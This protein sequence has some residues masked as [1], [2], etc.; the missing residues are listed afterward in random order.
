VEEWQ[1]D[2]YSCSSFLSS[3]SSSSFYFL[4]FLFFIF[5]ENYLRMGHRVQNI[6]K[7]VD[8]RPPI[9]HS[10]RKYNAKKKKKKKPNNIKG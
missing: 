6:E 2:T 5:R 1:I 7:W 8:S 10:K 9:T 3:S 4:F